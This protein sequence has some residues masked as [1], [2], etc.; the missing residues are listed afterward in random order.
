MAKSYKFAVLKFASNEM[1]GECLNVGLLVEGK[2]GLEVL[3]ASRLEKLRAISAAIEPTEIAGELLELP[4]LVT[5]FGFS[6]FED[7]GSK[8][9]LSEFTQFT[10]TQSGSFE[11]STSDI[12][13]FCINDLMK[14]YVE[15]E[16][17]LVR[18]VRKRPSRLRQDIKRALLTEKILAR[19]M[20]GLESHRVIYKHQLA[21]GVIADFVLQNGAMHVVESVDATAENISLHRCLY[22]IAMSALTFEHARINFENQLVRPKLIYSSSRELER[23]MAPSLYAAQHQGAELVN[24]ESA[25]ERNGFITSFVSMADSLRDNARQAAMFHASSVPKRNLN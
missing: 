2:N 21:E 14:R 20:E 17:A 25:D 10:I 4:E 8:D 24:W 18:P 7:G 5:R 9:R 22:E 16:P 13:S 12:Y 3:P 6:P 15:P 23:A 1:R 11:A 19:P